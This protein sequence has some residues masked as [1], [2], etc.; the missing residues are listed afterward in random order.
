MESMVSSKRDPRLWPVDRHAVFRE[1]LKCIGI[2]L[3]ADQVR[4]VRVGV[5]ANSQKERQHDDLVETLVIECLHLSW[6][7][8]V[9]CTR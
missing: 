7:L 4:N 8:M 1:G 6:R 9:R 2:V 5:R 3:E